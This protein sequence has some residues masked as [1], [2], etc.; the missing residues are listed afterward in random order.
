[1]LLEEEK[2]EKKEEKEVKKKGKGKR[3]DEWKTEKGRRKR[4]QT[5]PDQRNAC[6]PSLVGG[7]AGS[8]QS[9]KRYPLF[10]CGIATSFQLPTYFASRAL[11]AQIWM[12]GDWVRWLLDKVNLQISLGDLY[13]R[14]TELGTDDY[15]TN[16]SVKSYQLVK[17]VSGGRAPGKS[18]SLASPQLLVIKRF[19][20]FGAVRLEKVQF[21]CCIDF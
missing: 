12:T 3:K 18:S 16:A 6:W 5:S 7:P 13:I 8:I 17:V 19:H 15:C 2:E 20:C 9:R 1:M 10:G 21:F 14:K 11:V 4:L